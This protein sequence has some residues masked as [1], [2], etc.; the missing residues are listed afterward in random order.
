MEKILIYFSGR[1]N[2]AIAAVPA[3]M[4]ILLGFL[5]MEFLPWMKLKN[6]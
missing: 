4:V 6:S 1:G 3:Q 2:S 5:H